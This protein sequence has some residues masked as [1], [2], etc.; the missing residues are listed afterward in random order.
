MNNIDIVIIVCLLLILLLLFLLVALSLKM[1]KT[2]S[3]YKAV[4][5]KNLISIPNTDTEF[6]EVLLSTVLL[7]M[8]TVR[9]SVHKQTMNIH[10]RAIQIAPVE[11]GINEQL[12]KKHFKNDERIII[13]TFWGHFNEYLNSYWLTKK[14]IT[15][16]VFTGDMV[17]KTGDVGKMMVA[18]EHL[19][20][21]LDL[22]IQDLQK[23]M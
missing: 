10:A 14:G 3:N 13:A 15:K 5:T 18:S 4:Q 7:K 20:F 2:L 21:K 1:Y 17:E 9:N 23:G 11:C 8:Y 6:R 12:L 22:L 16:T 19:V